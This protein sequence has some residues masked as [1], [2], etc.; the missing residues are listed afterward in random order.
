MGVPGLDF[1]ALVHQREGAQD[2]G[3]FGVGEGVEL[4]HQRVYFGAELLAGGGVGDAVRPVR[5]GGRRQD[6][7]FGRRDARPALPEHFLQQGVILGARAHQPRGALHK[8]PSSLI[9]FT[10]GILRP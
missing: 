4:G 8:E 10:A 3:E 7:A 2:V 1:D 9:Q 5:D 6:A